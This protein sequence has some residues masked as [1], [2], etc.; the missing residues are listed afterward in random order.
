M[1]HFIILQSDNTITY[2]YLYNKKGAIL[3][4]Q[5]A[6]KNG[7][8][9]HKFCFQFVPLACRNV[10]ARGK[11]CDSTSTRTEWKG[12]GLAQVDKSKES[13]EGHI[14]KDFKMKQT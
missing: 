12:T 2:A 14:G 10:L 8:L 11:D 6:G 13:T 9:L 4:G 3:H 7:N 5:F 1:P